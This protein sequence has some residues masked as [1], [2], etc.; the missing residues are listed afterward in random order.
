MPFAVAA[1][2]YDRYIGRYSR[3]LAPRFLDFAQVAAGPVLDLGCGSGSLTGVLAT[4]RRVPRRPG[5]RAPGRLRESFAAAIGLR[6]R[7][8]NGKIT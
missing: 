6:L 5:R 3:A 7:L 8:A 2:A 1:D 4:G